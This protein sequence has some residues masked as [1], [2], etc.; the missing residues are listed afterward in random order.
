MLLTVVA[1]VV[2]TLALAGY[3]YLYPAVRAPE[4]RLSAKVIVERFAHAGRERSVHTFAPAATRPGAPLLLALH[5]SAGSAGGMREVTGYALD[6]LAEEHGFVVAYPE[7]FHGHWN[8]C[9]RAGSF[10]AKRLDVDDVG[11]LSAVV[12]RLKNA[13]HTGPTFAVGYSN[14]GHMCFRLAL[15]APALLDGIGVIAANLPTPDNCVCAA[16]SRPLPVIFINGTRDPINPYLGGRVTIFGFGDR[17]T[18]RSAADSAAYF[19]QRLGGDVRPLGPDVVVPKEAGLARFVE[20]TIWSAPGRGD[21]ALYT[22]HGGGHVV[23]QPYYRFPRL[24]GATEMRFN[25]LREC[26]V[27]FSRI[28]ES[29]T[30]TR[31]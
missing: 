11:F 12:A 7:G 8:D 28:V 31:D 29:K 3:W 2:V 13:H 27:F 10:A 17:G 24:V 1:V 26:W 16:A 15:D 5:P 20:R 9:R 21:V 6:R 30:V 25:A 14:G 22:V 4:P 18:V 19:A 23:P